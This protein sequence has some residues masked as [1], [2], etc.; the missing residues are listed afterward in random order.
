[1]VGLISGFFFSAAPRFGRA[2]IG[3][4]FLAFLV[5][6]AKPIPAFAQLY[7]GSLTG[8]VTDPSGAVIPDAQ[9]T[10]T[11]TGKGFDYKT[12]T[13]AVGRYLLRSL[14]PS[15][16]KLTVESKGFAQFAQDRIALDVNENATVDVT[17]RVG[18]TTQA[19][20]VKATPPMLESQDATTGQEI[21]RTFINDLPLIGRGVTDLAFLA[22]GVNP[23][24]GW[25]FGSINGMFTQNNFTSNGGRNATSDMLVD[26]VSATGYEQNTAIQI[27]LYMPSVDDV[28]EFKLQQN[29]FSADI[30]YSSNTVINVVTRSGNN[31]FHGSAYEFVRNQ[32]FDSNNWFNNAYG[33]NLLP[34]RYNDF[35]ATAG[36]PIRKDKMFF[37]VDY[38]GT[39]Q[40]T[41]SSA[42]TAGV[43]SAAERAGDFGEL[44]TYAGGTFDSNGECNAPN[45]AGQIW[46]PYSGVYN[47]NAGGAIRSA[48]I[49]FNNMA[50]YQSPG[51]PNLPAGSQLPAKPGNLIDPVAS[52]IM[53]YYP[54]PNLNVGQANYNPYANWTSNGISINDHDQFD[55]R[56]DQRFGNSDTLSGRFSYARSPSNGGAICFK[57]PL[58]PCSSGPTAWSQRAIALNEV[59]TFSPSTVLT[60]AY[61]FAR[62]FVNQPGAAANFPSFDPISGLGLPSYMAASGVK[63][64]PVIVMYGGYYSAGPLNSIGGQPWTV[65][66]YAQETHHL[67]G[68]LD[69]MQG[70][71]EFKFGGEM[72]VHRTNEGQ[73][74]TPTG[75]FTFDYNTTSEGPNYGGGDAMA[76][77]LTGTSTTGWGQYEIPPYIATQN[78]GYAW[79]FQDNYR[80]SEKLTVNLGA[81]YE[82]E[83]PRTE[84]HNRQAWFDP[85][86]PSPLGSVP[87][88]GPIEGGLVYASPSERTNVNTN[89]GGIAPRLGLAYRL[90]PKLVLRGGYGIFYNPSQFV[91]AG[92]SGSTGGLDGYDSIT[93][94]TTTYQ[95]DGATPWGRLSNPFPSGL[96]FPSGNTLGAMTSVG[97]GI[98]EYLRNWNALPYTQTWNGGFQYQLPGGMVVEANYIGTKGTHLY[99]GGAG[100]LNHLGSWVESASPSEISNLISYVNNPFYGYITNPTYPLSNPTVQALQL[101]YQYPQYTGISAQYPPFANSIYN[102]FQLRIE[103]RLSHGL[104]LLANYTNS[105]AIDDASVGT[106]TTW[107][108]GSHSL[109]DPNNFKLERSV[110]QYDIP[111]VLNIAYVYQ[112]PFGRGKHWGGSWNRW[113]DGLL[114]GWQTNGMWRF[115]DGQPMGLGMQGGLA[116]PGGYGQRP[117]LLGPLRENPRSKWFCSNPG[118][119]FFSNQG[120]TTESTDVAVVPPDYTLGT[121]PRE[122][123]SP[124]VPGTSTSALSLFKEINMTKVREGAR[125]ELRLESFNALNHPQFGGPNTTVNGG[126]FGLMTWQANSPREVQIALKLYW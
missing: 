24:P 103:K 111:Q 23:A 126:S 70:R 40:R 84:R 39:R 121:A 52:K 122:L 74:G 71:H 109:V 16:Y 12:T 110:S 34:L 67:I 112:L 72:R 101:L 37:F 56:I 120:A 21:N 54:L 82:L 88:V 123:D 33:I 32:I 106:N 18:A 8:V 99:F 42:F 125:A 3:V 45:G 85:T 80:V 78:I 11:D 114:G 47:A 98:S 5:F 14:P 27:P 7:S 86:L 76:G 107:L 63:A 83:F 6:L 90:T 15:I 77:L 92:A 62:Q 118:C 73:P 46:D 94:W 124:R 2:I 113:M 65:L 10:L 59:H 28:Q 119:G 79:Y 96:V 105:K 36:G 31:S 58:D 104:Q 108:G 38:E 55:T 1:M 69:R 26:G 60:L 66:R 50:T 57:D 81:R 64:T 115:D 75:Y 41:M 22:P 20:E 91:A 102:A 117:D 4:S 9:V 44:C 89:F 51:N 87:G 35:G 100:A 13:N 43:P 97:T 116:L 29:N 49:P 95:G 25:T 30:G 53:S 61:G 19:V 17:L 93:S 48:F 68:A